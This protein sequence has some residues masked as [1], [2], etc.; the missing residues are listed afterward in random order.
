VDHD[1]N[2]NNQLTNFPP[3]DI[4][5]AV[6]LRRH[7]H[8]DSNHLVVHRQVEILKP[9]SYLGFDGLR[10]AGG[11]KRSTVDCRITS[12][13]IMATMSTINSVVSA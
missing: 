3:R 13:E 10:P 9:V 11:V 1:H 6:D 12:A 5:D 4:T 7:S 8:P 2:V